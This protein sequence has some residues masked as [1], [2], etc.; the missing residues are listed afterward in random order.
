MNALII[1]RR[2]LSAILTSPRAYGVGATFLFVI[3]L[4][5]FFTVAFH[6]VA[7]LLQVFYGTAV[8]LLFI[9]PVLTMRLFSREA[10][11]GTLEL[12]LTAPI[13]NWEVVLGK[14]LAVILF[15]MLLL[16]P[17]LVYLI[18]LAGYGQPDLP[19]TLSGY[20]GVVLLAM[21]LMSLGLL[22]SALTTHHV[23]AAALAIGLSLFFGLI[24]E[25]SIL[26]DGAVGNI[27]SYLSFQT[28]FTDFVAGLVTTNN[29][30]Y[31]LS[32]TLAALFIT[33]QVLQVRR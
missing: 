24:G 10:R 33:T 22:S 27:L 15:F 13:R 14:F 12:L 3:G 21:M 19:V 23:V 4:L 1:A 5:F 30:I 20:L 16:S 2:E 6:Q 25:L 18:L 28:H 31:F 32:I 11:S 17:T 9:A 26:F 8:G 7:T 29:I